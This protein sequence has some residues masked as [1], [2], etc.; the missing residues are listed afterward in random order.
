MRKIKTLAEAQ[1]FADRIKDNPIK[2]FNDLSGGIEIF[3]EGGEKIDEESTFFLHL[4]ILFIINSTFPLLL[5]LLVDKTYIHSINELFD[6]ELIFRKE[7]LAEWAEENGYT[8]N[9]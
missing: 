3:S 2:A 6:P 8:K 5:P 1:E 4:R 7:S 9:E